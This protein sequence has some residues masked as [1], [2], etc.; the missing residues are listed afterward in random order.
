MK[1]YFFKDDCKA[2]QSDPC[3]KPSQLSGGVAPGASVHMAQSAGGVTP[4]SSVHIGVVASQPYSMSHRDNS[5]QGQVR[6]NTVRYTLLLYLISSH[7]L[8]P[9]Y[10]KRTLYGI[11]ISINT[12]G[13]YPLYL[14]SSH[15]F[16]PDNYHLLMLSYTLYH[17]LISTHWYY[18]L[19]CLISFCYIDPCVLTCYSLYHMLIIFFVWFY[20]QFFTHIVKKIVQKQEI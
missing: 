2:Q 11:H 14:I 20:Q 4:G 12:L 16:I 19:L 7:Y 8:I 5:P 6:E 9:Y 17:L 18:S 3:M 15:Y 10:D 1:C 13:N